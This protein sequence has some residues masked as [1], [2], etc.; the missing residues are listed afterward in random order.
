M[1]SDHA[2]LERLPKQIVLRGANPNERHLFSFNQAREYAY[3]DHK[4]RSG[5][6]LGPGLAV[7]Y[8]YPAFQSLW[9]QDA[10]CPYQFAA[11]NPASGEVTMKGKHLP[12]RELVPSDPPTGHADRDLGH[13]PHSSRSSG[14]PRSSS[15]WREVRKQAV[16]DALVFDK[17]AETVLGEVPSGQARPRKRSYTAAYGDSARRKDQY[18]RKSR[19][20]H[21]RNGGRDSYKVDVSAGPSLELEERSLP[22]RDGAGTPAVATPVATPGPAPVAGPTRDD[23]LSGRVDPSTPQDFEMLSAFEDSMFQALLSGSPLPDAASGTVPSSRQDDDPTA[24]STAVAASSNSP[25]PNPEGDLSVVARVGLE[26]VSL[27]PDAAPSSSPSVAISPATAPSHAAAG[28]PSG[29]PYPELID[30]PPTPELLKMSL[31]DKEEARGPCS[32]G[33]SK[34]DDKMEVDGEETVDYGDSE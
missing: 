22:T 25:P 19:A 7:P 15:A 1:F 23:L 4:L 11:Y 13:R 12:V 17:L 26:K 20:V 14:G 27:S 33:S 3:F 29:D 9:A 32:A 6:R 8:G 16:I 31:K 34:V 18:P 2:Y 10:S 30:A 5:R 28:G 21:G 24:S